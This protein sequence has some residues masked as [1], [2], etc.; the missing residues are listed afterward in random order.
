MK[1]IHLLILLGSALFAA[2]SYAASPV[3][4]VDAA[5]LTVIGKALPT[6]LPYNRIDTARFRVP[7][8]TAGFCYHSTGLA[9]VFRTD[10][11]TICARWET[12][13]KNPGANMTAIAQKGLDLYIRR[14]GE[15]VF[16]G[17]GTPKIDGRNDR[18]EATLVSTLEEGEK[19]CLLYLPLYDQLKRLEIGVDRQSDIA[20]ME[21]PFRRRIVIHGSSITHGIA[22][23]RAG[24]CYSSRLG[25]DL[26]LYF[27]N[28]GFS[29]QCTMQPEFA[30]YL[31]HIEADAFILDCFSNP[32]AKTIDERF[33]AFVDTLRKAHPATPLIF[34]QT[35]RRETRNF[36]TKIEK[37]ESD[38]MAAAEARIRERMKTDKHIYFVAPGD[39]LGSDHI[40]TTDGIHPTDLGFTRMLERIEPPIRKILKKYGIR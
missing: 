21:N 17:V 2:A 23:G 28:L 20:P 11:R 18:H 9:V 32:S 10:S 16:A 12:S 39:L 35:I 40:A 24:M 37:F 7:A 15:W 8:K 36:S 31:A 3:R 5:T 14:G 6:E 30:S 4:Y 1:H 25:R 34:L 26:G 22:A 13:G 19:E 33:D 29:G 38:K 27:I